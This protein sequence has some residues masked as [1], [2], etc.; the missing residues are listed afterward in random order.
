MGSGLIKG[1]GPVMAKRIVKRFGKD[2]LDVI[3]NYLSA[4][5]S[6]KYFVVGHTD[7]TG[8][9]DHNM[10]LSRQR[11][12]AVVDALVIRGISKNQL[13]AMGVGPLSPNAPNR[14]EDGKAQN[15]RVELVEN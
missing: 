12:D 5:V 7:N 14:N 11:A 9:M 2:T 13:S 10:N 4:N 3:A 15:R 8:S 1:I 6:S